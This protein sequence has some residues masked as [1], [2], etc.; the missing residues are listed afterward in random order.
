MKTL[1]N[2]QATFWHETELPLMSSQEGS[3]AKTLALQESKPELAKAQE[4]DSGPS[5]GDF[6]ANYDR[7]TQSLKTSQHCLVARLNGQEDGLAEY[8]ATWPRSGMMRS[9][10]ISRLPSLERPTSVKESGLLPTPNARDGKDLSRT[11]AYLAARQRHTPSLAT[12][13]LNAAFPWYQVRFLY[14]LAMGFPLRWTD[15]E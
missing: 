1:Q 9:G 3:L 12:V 11:T 6:L 8:S 15:A 10:A 4:A 13:A 5:A 7:N 2:S 14:E